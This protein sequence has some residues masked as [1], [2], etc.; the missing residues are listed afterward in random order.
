VAAPADLDGH[1]R[2]PSA[3]RLRQRQAILVALA[4][5]GAFEPRPEG[6][7]NPSKTDASARVIVNTVAKY[8]ERDLVAETLRREP[9][10]PLPRLSWSC[11]RW[12]AGVSTI[13]SVVLSTL[14]IAIPS[15]P[16]G[17][18]VDSRE[19][20]VRPSRVD[21]QRGK[22]IRETLRFKSPSVVCCGSLG[23]A[24][25]VAYGPAKTMDDRTKILRTSRNQ[26]RAW[27]R[28]F[29]ALAGCSADFPYPDEL[30]PALRGIKNRDELPLRR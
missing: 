18:V 1:L 20:R 7:V 9:K 13:A 30:V 29:R 28:R 6:R 26:R 21:F 5:I 19:D 10:E 15:P 27:S 11:T 24:N 3:S 14:P 2:D 8:P 22:Q 17:L 4:P 12:C 16:A 25:V 23:L